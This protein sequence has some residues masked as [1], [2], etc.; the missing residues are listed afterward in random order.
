MDKVLKISK[1]HQC[2]TAVITELLSKQKDINNNFIHFITEVKAIKT[3]MIWQFD[4][5]RLKKKKNLR[6]MNKQIH[7]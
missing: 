7:K 6:T 2:E 4:Y 5:N 3:T 1:L